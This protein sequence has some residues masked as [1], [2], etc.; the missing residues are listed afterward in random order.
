[1]K[2]DPDVLIDEIVG[3]ATDRADALIIIELMLSAVDRLAKS[4]MDRDET[5]SFCV[6]V[7]SALSVIDDMD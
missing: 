3:R 1:M 4:V 6:H 5:N 2:K 7:D